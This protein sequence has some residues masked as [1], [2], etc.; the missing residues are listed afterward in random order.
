MVGPVE[1]PAIELLGVPYRSAKTRVTTDPDLVVRFGPAAGRALLIMAHDDT[2]PASP[3]GVDH[4]AA[5][6]VVLAFTANEEIGLVGDEA[7]VAH[8]GDDVAFAIALDLIGASG[9]LSLNGA[10][11]LIGDAELGWIAAAADRAGVVVRAPLPHR[12]VSRA[13]LQ[14][15]RSDHGPFT[16]HR[17]PALHFYD[18]GQ[19]GAWIDLAYHSARDTLARVDRGALDEIGRLLRAL[20][21]VAPPAHRGDGLWLPAARNVV[22]PRWLRGGAITPAAARARRPRPRAATR[23]PGARTSS[24]GIARCP[25]RAETRIRPGFRRPRR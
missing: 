5:V 22:V 6:G 12:V 19:D 7:L 1:V 21:A 11:R 3:G 13:W 10:S 24:P 14:V 20:T 18:R 23:S 8:H 17:S 25:A 16:R 4:S 15:E 2:V 9:A